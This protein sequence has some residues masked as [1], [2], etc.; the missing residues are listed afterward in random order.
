MEIALPG[1]K[2]G[3]VVVSKC[4]AAFILTEGGP[5]LVT[6]FLA[7]KAIDQLFLTIAPQVAGR[8]NT[9]DRPA[10][11]SGKMFA[12]ASPLWSQLHT[13]RRSSEFLYLCY[14]FRR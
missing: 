10:F 11:V 2:L 5:R 7:D 9:V 8:D 4:P 13:V 1:N 6:A 14:G 12:P 3:I